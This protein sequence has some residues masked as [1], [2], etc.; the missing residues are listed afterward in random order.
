MD[1]WR[2]LK[3]K[4]FVNLKKKLLDFFWHLLSLLLANWLVPIIT[5]C[6]TESLAVTFCQGILESKILP[7]FTGSLRLKNNQFFTK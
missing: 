6:G 3:Y 1:G 4:S 2:L 5:N 7:L